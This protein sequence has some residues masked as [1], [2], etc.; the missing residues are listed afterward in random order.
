MKGMMEYLPQLVVFL[1]E[2]CLKDRK[3][4]GYASTAPDLFE[5]FFPA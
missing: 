3:V 4:F 2:N 5:F 1:I